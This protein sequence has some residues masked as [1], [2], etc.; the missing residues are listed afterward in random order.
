MGLFLEQCVIRR[1]FLPQVA[2]NTRITQLVFGNQWERKIL[3]SRIIIYIYAFFAEQQLKLIF[4][5]ISIQ[6]LDF[7]IQYLLSVQI[8]ALSKAFRL[9]FCQ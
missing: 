3:A 9:N 2:N 8:F 5:G 1:K 7:I 6:S 4:R